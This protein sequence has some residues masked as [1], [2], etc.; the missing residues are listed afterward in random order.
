MRRLSTLVSFWAFVLFAALLA[1]QVFPYTGVFLMLFGAAFITGIV[2]HVFLIALVVEA[3]ARRVP[4]FLMVIPIVAMVGITAC[5]VIKHSRL[6][7]N[8]ASCVPRIRG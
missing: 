6:R 5:L 2:L 7:V 1:L 3:F 4:R 8:R